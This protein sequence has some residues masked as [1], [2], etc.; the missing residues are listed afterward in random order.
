MHC[1]LSIVLKDAEE[2]EDGVTEVIVH[3]L[4]HY[5]NSYSCLEAHDGCN[6]LLTEALHLSGGQA[7]HV[8]L[9]WRCSSVNW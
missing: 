6:D 3:K 9:K 8:Q 1:Q 7:A 5:N 4:P 2:E